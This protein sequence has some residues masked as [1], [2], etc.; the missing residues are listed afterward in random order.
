MK[1]RIGAIGAP[2]SLRKIEAVADEDPRI[3]LVVFEY[4]ELPELDEILNVHRH[5]VSQWIF[6]GSSPYLYCV[7]NGLI[8][9]R[10]AM[11]PP[12]HGMAL[13][14]TCLRVMQELG[15]DVKRMSLDKVDEELVQEMF[16]EYALDRLQ[17]ELCPVS[18]YDCNDELIAFH[19]ECFESGK[20]EVALTCHLG[21]YEELQN[22]GIPS[23][24]IIPPKLAIR[25]V[26]NLLVSRARNH[27]YGK[28][29]MAILGLAVQTGDGRTCRIAHSFADQERLLELKT[30]L[31]EIAKQVNGSLV[32][33]G[34]SGFFIYTTQGDYELM[35]S[36]DPP[37]YRYLD[38]I[39]SRLS[40]E[41]QL[42][43][44]VGYT[45]YD[46]EQNVQ[47]AFDHA[48]GAAGTR[49]I[50]VDE[51][52]NLFDLT[53]E[54]LTDFPDGH[55]PE[56]WKETLSR[57]QYKPNIPAKLYHYMQIKGL[58]ELTSETLALILKN[59]E[60]NSRRILNE[61]EQLKLIEVIREESLGR[62][63]RPRKVYRLVT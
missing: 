31:L 32:E 13:L 28:M 57:H 55:L 16:S 49:I 51:E 37:F 39:M 33:R 36:S 3:E 59:T 17:F 6:S 8:T 53:P 7:E 30:E 26:F 24:R 56:S 2:D 22:R 60:R 43:I 34:A 47:L 15:S 5:S 42:V 21:V 29:K 48:S 50:A 38:E 1:V 25:T 18:G 23:F 54:R 45:V 20:T 63:G 35:E 9:S 44:G 12:V 19:S 41:Y 10:E 58:N 46:A 11:Y 52:K 40:F 27:L 14:G 62:P 61:L 4:E